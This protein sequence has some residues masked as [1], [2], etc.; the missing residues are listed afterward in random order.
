MKGLGFRALLYPKDLQ[1]SRH[2][3]LFSRHKAENCR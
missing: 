3:P 2:Y 1:L